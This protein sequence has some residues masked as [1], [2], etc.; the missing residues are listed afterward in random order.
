MDLKAGY[1]FSLIR[2]GLPYQYPKLASSLRTDVIIVGGGISGALT[3]Y[4]LH[5]AGVDCAVVDGRSIGLGSTSASTSLLQ[6][7]I[8]VPL[9]RLIRIR[10]AKDAVRAYDL[11]RQAIGKL[12]S[13]ASKVKLK[14]FDFNRSLYF[15]AHKKDV[16][17]LHEEF[18][19]RKAH[20]FNVEFLTEK[21][22]KKKFR[23]SS[24]AAI[25]S[26]DGAYADAYLL[27][28]ELYQHSIR[29][30]LKVFDRTYIADVRHHRNGVVL[31]TDDG[32]HI[33]AKKIIYATGYEVTEFV[34]KKIVKLQSTYV[35][36][37]EHT[38]GAA[39]LIDQDVMMWNT[40][41]P[42]LYLRKTNDARILI[43]GRDEEFYNP[44]R[45]D[46]LIRRKSGLLVK[47]FQRL[48]PDTDF[49]PEFNWAG[50]FGST[51]DG[52]P[53]IGTW[54]KFPRSYFALGF[55][56]NGITFSLIAAEI[57]TD[58]ML[59]KKNKDARIFSFDRI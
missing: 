18:S 34:R 51:V 58:L 9:T 37:S 44:A 16:G 43:G 47:D 24:P 28:H 57:L 38:P 20:G 31:T 4:H 30:G 11:C 10:G 32:E 40:A 59:G 3:A 33:R 14:E 8:D 41:D 17:F 25:L 19:M 56:G 2:Y 54:S 48:F 15:A 21:D 6:Y 39:T 53:F 49:K 55:G 22:I 50:T 13:I 27:T 12:G 36:I 26:E 5:K 52:L 29:S 46:K 42:Y 35:T 1:P 7:E 45:R 23:F